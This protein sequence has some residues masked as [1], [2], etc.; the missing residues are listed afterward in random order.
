MIIHNSGLG[1]SI[2]RILACLWINTK[3]GQHIILVECEA[4]QLRLCYLLAVQPPRA[5]YLTYLC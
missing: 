2:S 3:G 1:I 4:E 5:S